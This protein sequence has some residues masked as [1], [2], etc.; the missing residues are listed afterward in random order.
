[1][2]P[3]ILMLATLVACA[4]GSGQTG[5][6]AP[7]TSKPIDAEIDGNGCAMQ[8]CTI[9]PQCG[10]GITSACDVDTTDSMGT[11]CRPVNV[12]GKETAACTG[13]DKCDQGYVCLGGSTYATCKKYCTADADCGTPRGRCA[14]DLTNAGMVIAD[15]PPACSSNCNPLPASPP[16]DCPPNYKCSLFTATHAGAPV[17]IADCNPAGTGTQ[18][19]SCGTTNGNDSMC[20][21]GYLCTTIGSGFQCRRICN[22]SANT[23]CSGS[24][25]CLGFSVPHTIDIEY[26]VCN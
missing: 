23:G 9:L 5:D 13:I 16:S 21:P 26:G 22:K 18:G 19:S 2:R 12:P 8:P 10:C 7:D 4:K 3:L 20:A 11:T 17:K 25:T 6:A 1:M 14:I 24:Q 15:I